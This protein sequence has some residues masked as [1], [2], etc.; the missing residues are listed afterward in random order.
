MNATKMLQRNGFGKVFP[1]AISPPDA[2]GQD[3][4]M[5]ISGYSRR[6]QSV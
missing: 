5:R 2:R 1:E 3:E 6:G 4:V